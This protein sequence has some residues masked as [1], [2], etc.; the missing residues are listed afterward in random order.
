[1]WRLVDAR[2]DADHLPGI[3]AA[4]GH[5]RAG[6]GPP[7]QPLVQVSG[8]TWMSMPPSPSIIPTTSRSDDPG[9]QQI[10]V[11]SDS[12]GATH[13]FAG[14]CRQAGVGFSFGYAVDTRVRDATDILNANHGW[15]RSTPG[16]ASVTAPG[17]RWPPRW[18]R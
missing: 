14:A 2:V 5:A 6:R 16:A 18:S 4:R 7:V 9:A 10:L 11:R 8:C 12:A 15:S 17:S 13:S 3:R 1:M